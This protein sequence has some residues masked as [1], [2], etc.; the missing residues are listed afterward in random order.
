MMKGTLMNLILSSV[1]AIT[2]GVSA[3][4]AGEAPKG[5]CP[6]VWKMYGLFMRASLVC[7]FPNSPAISKV[8]V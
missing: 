6:N 3:A 1:A 5:E 2:M 8:L 4:N 7:N